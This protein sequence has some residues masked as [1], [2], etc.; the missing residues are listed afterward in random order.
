MQLCWEQS[1]LF[2]RGSIFDVAMPTFGWADGSAVATQSAAA[3]GC[4]HM[5]NPMT[6]RVGATV[7]V[8]LGGVLV[9]VCAGEAKAQEAMYT[10]AATMPGP[11]DLILREQF[12][13]FQYGSNPTSG[14][15]STK[16]YVLETNLQYGI[17]KDLSL[18]VRVPMEHELDTR[19]VRGGS[20]EDSGSGFDDLDVMLKY[21]FYRHDTGGVDTLRAAAIVGAEI[22]TDDHITVNPHIGAVVTMVRGRH[23]LNQELRW[24]FTTDGSEENNLGMNGP[25]DALSYNT[26]YLFRIYPE[27]FQSDSRGA[28]YVTMEMNGITETNGDTELRFAPGVMYEGREFAFELMTQFPLWNNLE[29]RAELDWG[30]GFG[31]R[32]LF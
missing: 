31:F 24:T 11:G 26:A 32:F 25:S 29:E 6:E 15:E 23:G 12:H 9:G 7:L 2:V 28:W 14:T 21:R 19:L 30:A 5:K 1:V 17:V 8:G 16:L 18:T 20:G 13:I 27:R 10:Q 3:M 22:D 4:M